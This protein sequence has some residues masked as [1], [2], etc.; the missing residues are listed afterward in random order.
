MSVRCLY[1]GRK[2][3]REECRNWDLLCRCEWRRRPSGCT[4]M[5]I[6]QV[7]D[8]VL[9]LLDEC[10]WV[11]PPKPEPKPG[12]ITE[13]RVFETIGMAVY[14]PY[15]VAGFQSPWISGALV[16][17]DELVRHRPRDMGLV[18]PH[19]RLGY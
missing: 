15:A 1:C 3:S 19:D 6:V 5:P 2:V 9:F 13:F 18:Q 12:E 8:D 16:V 4:Y 11:P 14:N 10:E 7:P 17:S